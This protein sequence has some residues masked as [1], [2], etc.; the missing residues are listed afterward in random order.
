MKIDL[1]E[2][3]H[4]LELRAYRAISHLIDGNAAPFELAMLLIFVELGRPTSE[5][6]PPPGACVLRAEVF[7]VDA[8]LELV[9]RA[10]ISGAARQEAIA[11]AHKILDERAPV[12]FANARRRSP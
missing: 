8:V 6:V 12:V 3:S 11:A 2:R 4:E 9:A 1:I 7:L 5:T 10:A